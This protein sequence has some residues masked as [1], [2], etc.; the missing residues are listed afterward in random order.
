MRLPWFLIEAKGNAGKLGYAMWQC[1]A[2]PERAV[3]TVLIDKD[4]VVR[5]AP[6]S[7]ASILQ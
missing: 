6:A 3:E 4:D 7:Q 5:D 1:V 2:A